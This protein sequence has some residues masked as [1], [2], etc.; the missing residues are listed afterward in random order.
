VATI[1]A[2]ATALA[3]SR[4][5]RK[6][7]SVQPP[8]IAVLSTHSPTA[9][10]RAP[11][12]DCRSRRYPPTASP[13][14]KT[15]HTAPNAA[16]GGV[17]PGLSSRRYQRRIFGCVGS[18]ALRRPITALAPSTT[19]TAANAASG[20]RPALSV[21]DIVFSSWLQRAT[22]GVV[23]ASMRGDSD[24]AASRARAPAT[25]SGSPN[26]CG[27]SRNAPPTAAR[28]RSRAP[29]PPVRPPRP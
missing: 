16:S 17:K 20:E 22:R 4:F 12:G 7:S 8:T 5:C 18:G 26:S 15:G 6:N 28:R 2:E 27:R 1:A 13:V 10:L 23:P 25:R 24:A 21:S 29:P 19:A 11:P 14:S 9:A 3:P